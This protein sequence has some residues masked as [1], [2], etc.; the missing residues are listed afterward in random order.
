VVGMWPFSDAMHSLLG[1]SPPSRGCVLAFEI[2][3]ADAV[4]MA[5]CNIVIVAGVTAVGMWS[6]PNAMHSFLGAS[7]PSRGLSFGFR[8]N[9]EWEQTGISLSQSCLEAQQF[10]AKLEYVV[11][12]I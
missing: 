9:I 2:I 3:W 6:F 11:H 8:D 1:T 5:T 10:A 4:G 7:P 12:F